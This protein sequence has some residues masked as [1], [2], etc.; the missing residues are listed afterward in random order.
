MHNNSPM[1]LCHASK[2]QLCLNPLLYLLNSSGLWKEKLAGK[3]STP[4]EERGKSEG[5]WMQHEAVKILNAR[6]N[7]TNYLLIEIMITAV[8]QWSPEPS[9]HLHIP[10]ELT[11][12]DVVFSI[13]WKGYLILLLLFK[14]SEFLMS[15]CANR[16]NRRVI[17][18]QGSNTDKVPP[19]ADSVRLSNAINVEII[20]WI[21]KTKF[22]KLFCAAFKQAGC[23][24][25]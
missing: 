13:W 17:I 24:G 15:D 8:C 5:S 11:S 7:M 2:V 6:I 12:L 16:L 18:L 21:I 9:A 22:W 23:E 19:A 4:L 25:F 3:T 14:T 10:Q 1:W 20:N